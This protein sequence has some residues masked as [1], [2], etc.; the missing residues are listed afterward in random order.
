M[1]FCFDG[2][3]VDK[4]LAV[5]HR[6]PSKE[7]IVSFVD[8]KRKGIV[9]L[10]ELIDDSPVSAEE[11]QLF[12][13]AIESVTPQDLANIIYTSG[14]T[15][16]PKG[17]M[18]TQANISTNI[19]DSQ[20]LLDTNDTSLSFLPLCYIAQRISDYICFK[21]GTTIAYA[22]SIARVPTNIREVRPAAL[23]GVPRFFE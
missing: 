22:E 3:Q 10:S 9:P 8:V 19:R 20:L 16:T 23:V 14:T 5:R 11:R 1:V 17:A 7:T 12:S 18:L 6:L 21:F 4:I 2:F 13:E 15:G